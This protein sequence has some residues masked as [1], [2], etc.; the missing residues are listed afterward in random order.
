MSLVVVTAIAFANA[1]VLYFISL[2]AAGGDGSADGVILVRWAGAIL[3]SLC[4]AVAFLLCLRRQQATGIAMAAASLPIAFALSIIADTAVDIF[5]SLMPSSN[6][7]QQMCKA[8]ATT[9]NKRPSQPVR[10]IAF[11]WRGEYRAQHTYFHAG[12]NGRVN[13]AGSMSFHPGPAQ[14]EFTEE[15]PESGQG[16]IRRPRQG[17]PIYPVSTLTA[18]VIVVSHWEPVPQTKKL[19]GMRR[20]E[21]TVSDRRNSELL[22]TTVYFLSA[23]GKL[24]CAGAGEGGAVDQKLF[25]L[26]A[27]GF[28]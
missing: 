16:F 19:S 6:E 1:V 24:G 15:R 23:D 21:V 7:F 11:D 9:Y 4:T 8:A 12:W 22:A 17:N 14:I 26:K 27:L 20:H 25:A 3:I 2:L 13:S 5:S 10:S 18:D 28:S